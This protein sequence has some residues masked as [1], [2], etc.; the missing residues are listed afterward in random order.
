MGGSMPS[1]PMMTTPVY[2]DSLPMGQ[3]PP[4]EFD[5]GCPTCMA[6]PFHHPHHSDRESLRSRIR[7]W[8]SPFRDWPVSSLHNA[9]AGV[10]ANDTQTVWVPGV[11]FAT[12]FGETH[13]TGARLLFGGVTDSLTGIN[14]VHFGGDLYRGFQFQS[15]H[16]QHWFKYGISLDAQEEFAK[17]GPNAAFLFFADSYFPITLDV[18]LTF[19]NDDEFRFAPAGQTLLGLAKVADRDFQWRLGMFLTENIQTGLVFNYV[20]WDDDLYGDYAFEFGLFMNWRFDYWA[21]QLDFSEDDD[22]GIRGFVNLAYT[23]GGSRRLGSFQ[24]VV[25]P[26]RLR[27]FTQTDATTWLLQPVNRDVSMRIRPR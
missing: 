8:L 6:E 7:N 11:N 4:G 25:A 5:P 23:W 12:L 18:S 14:S 24:E 20:D 17:I 10:Y 16:H 13:G 3:L 27:A 2:A 22:G 19:G 21:V 1:G 26:D 9:Q 15:W